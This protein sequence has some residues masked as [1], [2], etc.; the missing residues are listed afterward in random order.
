MREMEIN[1]VLVVGAGTMGSGI[2]HTF[3]LSGYEVYMIDRS[4]ELVSEGLAKV[5]SGLDKAIGK[6]TISAEDK[7]AALARIT[8]TTD[9]ESARE[10]DFA[11][12]AVFEDM[13]VKRETFRKLDGI[14]RPEVIL[15]SNTSSL[16]I[17]PMA[18]A[19]SRPDRFI[20]MHFFN[21]VPAMKLV[22]VIRGYRTSDETNREVVELTRKLGKT[23]V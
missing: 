7:Q 14:C 11:V 22:E 8:A 19:T 23:P 18:A 4:P 15:A 13:E 21:P 16:P 6:G 10:V 5:H 17:T 1:K 12:E 2:A 9:W 3:A 20:G